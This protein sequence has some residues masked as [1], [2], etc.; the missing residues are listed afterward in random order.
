MSFVKI[1]IFDLFLCNVDIELP[2][3]AAVPFRA[4]VGNE[5]NCRT[6]RFTNAERG[7]LLVDLPKLENRR[8]LSRRDGPCAAGEHLPLKRR[9]THW[10]EFAVSCGALLRA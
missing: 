8:S 10:I 3:P 6:V 2:S 9:H 5:R 1:P 7:V 4:P